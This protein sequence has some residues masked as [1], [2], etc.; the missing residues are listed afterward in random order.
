MSKAEDIFS[1]VLAIV[2]AHRVVTAT[3][4]ESLVERADALSV[5]ATE[6]PSAAQFALTTVVLTNMYAQMTEKLE[7]A[8]RNPEYAEALFIDIEEGNDARE[9]HTGGDERG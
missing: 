2:E 8:A 5:L 9:R 4:S 6:E 3:V 1:E 7:R